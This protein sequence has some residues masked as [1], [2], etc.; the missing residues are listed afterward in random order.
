MIGGHLGY[1]EKNLPEKTFLALRGLAWSFPYQFLGSAIPLE[2]KLR[3]TND[4]EMLVIQ[5]GSLSV[6]LLAFTDC[7]EEQ[8]TFYQ[9]VDA[10]PN[11]Q[12]Y[13]FIYNNQRKS[14]E[15]LPCCVGAVVTADTYL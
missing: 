13:S 15:V 7:N 12:N 14:S 6:A 3:L 11:H 10:S 1:C 8:L 5:I 2:C 9:W 4:Y